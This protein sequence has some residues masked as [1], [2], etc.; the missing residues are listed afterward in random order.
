MVTI[1]AIFRFFTYEELSPSA[2]EHAAE[3]LMWRAAKYP[4][5][6]RLERTLAGAFPS[7]KLEAELSWWEAG[8]ANRLLV[9]SGEVA[10]SDVANG[11]I[12]HFVPSSLHLSAED[13]R[14]PFPLV[15]FE[16]SAFARLSA[17][18]PKERRREAALVARAFGRAL[19]GLRDDA[20]Q[21][22]KAGHLA[23]FRDPLKHA[24]VLYSA[25]G[26]LDSGGVSVS[27]RASL[28]ARDG[29]VVSRTDHIPG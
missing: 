1:T 9:F 6:G 7:S 2:K 15:D 19:L 28:L 10:L 8:R 21:N 4:L 17:P 29:A 24:G 27:E 25:D 26:T 18:L 16:E 23:D 20:L 3:C 11:K 22:W 13:W 5:E 14:E 12:D